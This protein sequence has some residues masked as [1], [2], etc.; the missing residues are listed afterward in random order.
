MRQLTGP[1]MG[2]HPWPRALIGVLWVGLALVTATG[3]AR[4]QS[5]ATFR[6][7]DDVRCGPDGTLRVHGGARLTLF[8]RDIGR[9]EFVGDAEERSSQ[10]DDYAMTLTFR[11]LDDRVLFR[12]AS[13]PFEMEGN[14]SSQIVISG[15]DDRIDRYWDEI[16]SVELDA[17]V[18]GEPLFEDS[19]D[20]YGAIVRYFPEQ[21]L[22][23]RIFEY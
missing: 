13:E 14:R 6:W 2:R 9:F 3:T 16:D 10:G 4:A 11:D 7:Q 8:S 23:G 12:V 19:Y 5:D 17:Q 1:F 21:D 15:R 18:P 20:Y 22:E